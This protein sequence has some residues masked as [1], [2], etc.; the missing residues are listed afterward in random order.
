MES[1]VLL[2]F[3]ILFIGGVLLLIAR[4]LAFAFHAVGGNPPEWLL[5][6]ASVTQPRF[7]SAIVVLAFVYIVASLF[8]DLPYFDFFDSPKEA[9][10]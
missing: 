6:P 5:E 10:Q 7:L 3:L 8:L 2:L 1:V 9:V 4:I